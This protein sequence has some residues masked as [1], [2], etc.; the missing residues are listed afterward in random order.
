MKSQAFSMDIMIALVIFIGSI[1]LA[2]SFI[3]GNQDNKGTELKEDASIVLESLVSEDPDIGILNGIEVNETKLVELLG[4]EYSEIK[5]RIRIKNDF[6]LF[7][8][9]EN[10]NII[11][12][13][14][15]KPGIGSG[16]I[17]ISD[18]PCD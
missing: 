14:T 4:M 1:F 12:I 11:Y 6:C 17:R 3:T 15:D 5:E 18:I 16:K 13:E 10:G 9:D 8:E 2:Y 7:L